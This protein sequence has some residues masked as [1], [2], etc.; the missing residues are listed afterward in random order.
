M[1][2]TARAAVSAAALLL[3]ATAA[4]AADLP[5]Y[6]PAPAMV[7]VPSFT[8]S[9]FYVGA[10]AGHVWGDHDIRTRGKDAATRLN[11]QNRLRPPSVGVDGDGWLFGA[12]AGYNMQL[13]GSPIVFGVEA[14]ISYADIDDTR[15]Y[16]IPPLAPAAGNIRSTFK[17][18]LEYLG[19]VRARVGYAFDRV[20]VYGTGGLAYGEVKTSARFFNN[21]PPAGGGGALGFSDSKSN[22]EVGYTVGGGV[23]YA[24]TDAISVKG[25]Y[26]Y[27]DL[28][29]T[30]L[31][32]NRTAAA[33]LGQSGYKSRF[34]NDGH[35][36]RVGVNYRF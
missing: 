33:P 15:R 17:Q 14:D 4:S 34:E 20:L 11:V 10:H 21:Q 1:T 26:L 9:G 36:A 7:A 6:E 29:D 5:A 30:T 25:E 18:E 27:Y 2:A 12:Q 22:V 31:N 19:T 16:D 8:W 28:G 35:I 24:V 32:V 13:D 3:F 23:E